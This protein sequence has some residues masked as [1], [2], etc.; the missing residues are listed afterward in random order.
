M[1]YDLIIIGAGPAGMTAAVYARRRELKVLIIAKSTGGQMAL[2]HEVEN[3]P[4]TQSISGFEL[5]NSMK[6]QAEKWGAEFVSAEVLQIEKTATEF[7]V[8][9]DSNQYISGAVILAFGLTPKDLGVPGEKELI[10]KGVSYCATCDGP[11]F[12]NKKVAVIGDGNSALEAVEYL[13]KLASQIY[14]VIR[15]KEFNG[16]SVLVKTIKNLANVE[17][18]CCY[19]TSEIIGK[20]KVEGLK[21]TQLES[22]EVREL[23]VDG[24]FVEI[25]QAPKTGWLKELIDL[26]ERGEI[27][28]D[29]L[30]QTSVEGI[31]AAGDCTDVGYKQIIIAAGEGAKAALSAY[32]YIAAK[33]GKVATPD[34]G[35][36]K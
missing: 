25:G 34:W 5:A 8:K 13:A 33:A 19:A 2:A 4:G 23:E 3:W 11:F 9:T 29:K 15:V 12:R 1:N 6:T 31:F 17:I 7:I 21:L 20:A 16:E 22:N 35:G 24:V 27:I 10:G 36:K 18:V 28:S 30:T 26:N 32:K 14:L